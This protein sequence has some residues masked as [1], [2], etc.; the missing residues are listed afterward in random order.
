MSSHKSHSSAAPSQPL[1]SISPLFTT[2]NSNIP[3]VGDSHALTMDNQTPSFH[4]FTKLP[5]ELKRE[6]YKLLLCVGVFYVPSETWGRDYRRNTDAL[7]RD[8]YT[9]YATGSAGFKAQRYCQEGVRDVLSPIDNYTPGLILGVNKKVQRMVKEIFLGYNQFIIP[10]G[11]VTPFPIILY[12]SF[13]YVK[14]LSFAFDLRDGKG[15][16]SLC[17][18]DLIVAGQDD[19]FHD[20]FAGSKRSILDIERDVS[21]QEIHKRRIRDI[22][23]EWMVRIVRLKIFSCLRRLQ[24]DFYNCYCPIGCCRLTGFVC[25]I[26]ES[27]YWTKL[28]EKVEVMGWKNDRERLMIIST[29][30]R[31]GI[32]ERNIKLIP[33]VNP[34]N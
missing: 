8:I 19:V 23:H 6:I 32:D 34:R 28:P 24:I 29:L 14:D 20:S 30:N 3:N 27:S 18:G 22:K 33:L 5:E 7:Q 13:D 15:G 26:I 4:Y 10:V 16:G 1:L 11:H 9:P 25:G 31:V 2:F 17:R 21:L 12:S